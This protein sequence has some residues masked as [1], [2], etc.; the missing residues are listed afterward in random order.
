MEVIAAAA[1]PPGSQEI[2]HWKKICPVKNIYWVCAGQKIKNNYEKY[3]L[4]EQRKKGYN[5]FIDESI[6]LETEKLKKLWFVQWKIC[7]R[8]A[9]PENKINAIFL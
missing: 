4:P 3:W 7:I 1:R 6:F 9:H 2:V 8:S 5:I